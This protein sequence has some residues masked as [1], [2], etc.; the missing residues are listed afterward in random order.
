MSHQVKWLQ[1]G[2]DYTAI[3]G[4]TTSQLFKK[5]SVYIANEKARLVHKEFKQVKWCTRT[6]K[7]EG[8][9]CY[10]FMQVYTSRCNPTLTYLQL[11]GVAGKQWHTLLL[12]AQLHSSQPIEHY[13]NQKKM[14]GEIIIIQP[15]VVEYMQHTA[16]CIWQTTQT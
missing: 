14:V 16:K 5:I 7:I 8:C 2:E 1:E 10:C 12:E 4:P 3:C 15:S 6:D 11:F 13:S 9:T